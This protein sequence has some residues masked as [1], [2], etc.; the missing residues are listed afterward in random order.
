MNASQMKRLVR[1][2]VAYPRHP[3]LVQK[4][5]P[6]RRNGSGEIRVQPSSGKGRGERFWPE[7]LIA[8]GPCRLI[9]GLQ[10]SETSHIVVDEHETV[11]EGKTRSGVSGACSVSGPDEAAR[12]TKVYDQDHPFRQRQNDVF[13]PSLDGFEY[14]SPQTGG[15]I[16]GWL[17]QDVRVQNP[18]L[19]YRL[20]GKDR[21]KSP[22]DGFDLW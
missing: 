2:D 1:V 13:P 21:A 5:R 15:E 8:Q 22:D 10:A 9:H 19:F 16:P 11:V 4:P 14:P 12:H 18:Y 3:A 20:T 7:T 17:A 6:D